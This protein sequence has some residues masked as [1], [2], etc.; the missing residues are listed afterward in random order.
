[1]KLI[2][3]LDRLAVFTTVSALQ[4]FGALGV[5]LAIAGFHDRSVTDVLTG[6]VI[7]ETLA[8]V[9]ALSV[10]RPRL[11]RLRE[12]TLLTAT[13]LFSLP[14]VVQQLGLLVMAASDRFVVQ[15]D[16]GSAETGRYQI[17]YSLGA[18]I[19]IIINYLFAS[20]LPRVMQIPDVQ[21]RQRVLAESRDGLLRCLLPLTLGLALGGPLVMQVWAP[22]SF[23]PEGL[24]MVTLLVVVSTFA[25][26]FALTN[27]QVLLSEHRSIATALTTAVAAALNLALNI[28]LV[29]RFGIIGSAAATL[30]SYLALAAMLVFHRRRVFPLSAPRPAIWVEVLGMT[31]AI[32]ATWYI[33]VQGRAGV[34]IRAIGSIVCLVWAWNWLSK[35]RRTALTEVEEA[36]LS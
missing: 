23:H 13:L 21:T 3:C 11:P 8:L 30:V 27:G 32:F 34:T 28:I 17:A 4:S 5:G 12:R 7:V 9:I 29:P 14:L 22:Q 35:L 16:L 33:P 24:T 6:A 25:W 26:S 19:I 1:M 36:S 18:A 15:R 2:Q 20:W 31:A 10:A